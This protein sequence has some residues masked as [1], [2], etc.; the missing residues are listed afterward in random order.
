M[1]VIHGVLK[2]TRRISFE[3]GAGEKRQ[4]LKHYR[5]LPFSAWGER[6]GWT[7][8]SLGDTWGLMLYPNP[9]VL[10]DPK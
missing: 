10:S 9:K 3:E 4:L 7:T 1:K 2:K 8:A 6:P 5:Q